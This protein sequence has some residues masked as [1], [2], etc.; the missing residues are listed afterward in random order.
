MLREVSGFC[1]RRFPAV[2][3]PYA[4]F[5]PNDAMICAE[6][7]EC[8]SGLTK[9]DKKKYKV[10]RMSC[11]QK[12]RVFLPGYRHSVKGRTRKLL[13]NSSLKNM[14]KTRNFFRAKTAQKGSG[15]LFLHDFFAQVAIAFL[16]IRKTTS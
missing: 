5:T 14:H 11:V 16:F 4:N 7:K 2:I 1:L 10:H 9:K 6:Q 13:Q 12:K 8:C 15:F 3:P